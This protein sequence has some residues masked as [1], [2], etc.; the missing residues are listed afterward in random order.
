[1][2]YGAPAV[3]PAYTISPGCYGCKV[4]LW[5][6]GVG[7]SPVE[8]RA[9]L[10]EDGGVK[11]DLSNCCYDFVPCKVVLAS[12][13]TGLKDWNVAVAERIHSIAT[14]LHRK[15]RAHLLLPMHTPM[16]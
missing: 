13:T 14:K 1:M 2:K 15:V 12:E 5:F 11:M 8:D 10:G 16:G 9:D 4:T 7:G 3:F 6:I